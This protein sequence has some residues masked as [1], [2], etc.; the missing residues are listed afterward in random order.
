MFLTVVGRYDEAVVEIKRGIE[1]DP[2]SPIMN[3]DLGWI[4]YLSRDYHQSI[5]YSR[6]AIELDQNFYLA[7]WQLGH[8][9]IELGE[10][11]E[12]IS[13]CEK[14]V[15]LAG[16]NPSVQIGLGIAYAR[17]GQ[18]GKAAAILNDILLLKEE[19]YV[20]PAQLATFYSAF[21]DVNEA[22]ICF[23]E[24]FRQRDP[25]LTWTKGDPLL[26][27]IRSDARFKELMKKMG[28]EE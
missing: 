27:P 15:S 14:T 17:S 24:A 20:P 26:D 28:L 16:D 21:G 2:V 22:L 4:F 13:E 19:R 10:Y 3:S 5:K 18:R 6:K 25:S 11:E 12:A 8:A 23:D 9:L 7:H 1:L